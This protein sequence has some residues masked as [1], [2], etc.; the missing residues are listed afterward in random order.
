MS[1]IYTEFKSNVNSRRINEIQYTVTFN[2][3][4][5]TT[6]KGNN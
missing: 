4:I 3:T 1:S 2:L 5:I 6:V